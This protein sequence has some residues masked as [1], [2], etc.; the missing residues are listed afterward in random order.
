VKDVRE[1][2]FLRTERF[3]AQA[4][5]MYRRLREVLSSLT[6]RVDVLRDQVDRDYATMTELADTLHREAKI[7]FRTGYRVASELA[8]YG[9]ERGK[10][11]RDLTHAEVADVY[12]RVT[13]EALP[14]NEEQVR[15][16]FDPAFLVAN[17]KGRGGPQAA[18][19]RRMHA[20]QQDRRVALQTWVEDERAR[21][22]RA[23]EDLG[24]RF[25]ALAAD[26]AR[27]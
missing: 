24:R 27:R 23:S 6:I 21:L 13:N 14:L 15:Q 17:R 22:Q 1:D 5:D 25:D 9:R 10:R 11:P 16:A 19:V 2:H 8:T 4:S 12:R 18:E 20:G 3:A 7:P 26:G